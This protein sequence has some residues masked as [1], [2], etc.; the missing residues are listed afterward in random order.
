MLRL[1][2]SKTTT[3]AIQSSGM[4]CLASRC[5]VSSFPGQLR[6]RWLPYAVKAMTGDWT[7]SKP[8]EQTLCNGEK[9][10]P[11]LLLE[12][13]ATAGSEILC[14]HQHHNLATQD[15]LTWLTSVIGVCHR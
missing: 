2:L 11:R 5:V 8:C 1:L 10:Q 14:Q 13:D 7:H 3:T 4:V 15:E 12:S 9:A 6:K